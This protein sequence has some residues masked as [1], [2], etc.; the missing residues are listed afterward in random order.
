MIINYLDQMAKEGGWE[1]A[2]AKVD[3]SLY[4][5]DDFKVDDKGQPKKVL[6][7]SAGAVH[8]PRHWIPYDDS[9]DGSKTMIGSWQKMYAQGEDSFASAQTGILTGDSLFSNR[10]AT[11]GGMA[12]AATYLMFSPAFIHWME[13]RNPTFANELRR[14]AQVFDVL[15]T[16]KTRKMPTNWTQ[17]LSKELPNEMMLPV[18]GRLPDDR[19][20]VLGINVP[21]EELNDD[22]IASISLN[23]STE[24]A[25]LM[26]T[27]PKKDGPEI[28]TDEL[29]AGSGMGRNLLGC[30]IKLDRES[31]DEVIR[32]LGPRYQEDRSAV[33][34]AWS[35]R[36]SYRVRVAPL[37]DRSELLFFPTD[38]APYET[39]QRVVESETIKMRMFMEKKAADEWKLTDTEEQLTLKPGAMLPQPRKAAVALTGVEEGQKNKRVVLEHFPVIP[40]QYWRLL[41]AEFRNQHLYSQITNFSRAARA[42]REKRSRKDP[43]SVYQLWTDVFTSALA[44]RFISILPFWRSFQRYSSAF[45]ADELIGTGSEKF[46]KALNYLSLLRSMRRLQHLIGTA[47]EIEVIDK[48]QLYAEQEEI[49]NSSL[50]K[51][52]VVNV[53]NTEKPSTAES[54][55]GETYELLQPWQQNKINEFMRRA[56]QGTPSD[57]FATFIRGALTGIL[58]QE[59]NYALNQ[60]GRSFSPTMGRHPSTLRGEALIKPFTKGVGLLQNMNATKR[61]NT[62]MLPFIHSVAPESRMHAFNNGLIMGL[63]FIPKT[64]KEA[65]KDSEQQATE[66]NNP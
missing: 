63:A 50:I 7:K 5:F 45:S 23:T 19:M 32:L 48:I 3:V 17:S 39:I 62:R 20:I 15:C 33:L 42:G 27:A 53:M 61:F 65:S 31:D 55:L 47:R 49:E 24:L 12:K 40:L 13:T 54:L 4:E 16:G 57:Q 46:G 18:V 43:P 6:W 64:K 38:S 14:K 59:L 1:S 11:F 34:E 10:V 52:G 26:R 2:S 25:R 30:N 56:W 36:V 22:P 51:Y 37:P 21:D 9:S 28:I 44:R 8:I 35:H 29:H 60:E 41:E 58:L 66:N